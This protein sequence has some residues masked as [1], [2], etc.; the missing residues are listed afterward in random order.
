MLLR[1]LVWAGQ[2]NPSMLSHL[3]IFNVTLFHHFVRRPTKTIF[4]LEVIRNSGYETDQTS[5]F[6]LTLACMLVEPSYLY[7]REYPRVTYL[8]PAYVSLLSL[9]HP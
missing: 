1:T 2:A 8:S 4:Y 5:E 7:L 9:A 6:V 3:T